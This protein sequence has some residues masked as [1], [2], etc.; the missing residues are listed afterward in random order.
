MSNLPI[1]RHGLSKSRILLH[2]RCPKRLWLKVHR[3]ELEEIDDRNQARFSTGT[4]VGELAQQL[5]PEGVLIDGD[6]LAQAVLDTKAVF[7]G[8]KRPIFEATMQADGLLIRADL[9]LPDQNGYRM[10]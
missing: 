6:N 7:S 3:P 8:E 10:V 1:K 9:M 2:R 4:Y 5:Y